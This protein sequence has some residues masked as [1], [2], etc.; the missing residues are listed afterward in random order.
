VEAIKGDLSLSKVQKLEQLKAV[1][2]QTDPQVRSILSPE[3]YQKLKE[4]RHK[5]IEQAVKKKLD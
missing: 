4:I 5:E 1:H 3:Q 2:A